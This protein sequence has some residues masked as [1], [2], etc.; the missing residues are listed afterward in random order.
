MST[1]EDNIKY[2]K[3]I[4]FE[5]YVCQKDVVRGFNDVRYNRPYEYDLTYRT[6]GEMSDM[7]YERG[8]QLAVA[9][10]ALMS[11][12]EFMKLSHKDLADIK[13]MA[14]V[15]QTLRFR[16]FICGVDIEAAYE[17]PKAAPAVK[18][19]RPLPTL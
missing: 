7:E 2:K 11:P 15:Y 5:Q 14:A 1:V 4:T 3:S 10:Q 18:V 9:L 19:N 12:S 8:R 13:V 17:P 16:K 6:K